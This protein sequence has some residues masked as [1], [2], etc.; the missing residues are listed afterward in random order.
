MRFHHMVE[1]YTLGRIN[2]DML[3]KHIKQY[4]SELFDEFKF[5]ELEYLKIYPFLSEFQDEELYRE[6]ILKDK[7]EEINNILNGKKS[8]SYD[9]WMN[10]KKCELN[11]F[12]EI[13]AQYKEIGKI[14]FED[15][16]LLQTKLSN[17][18]LNK[19]TVEDICW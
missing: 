1:E 12:Y 7:I 4:F 2:A 10:L 17:I 14:S 8:F 6:D 15:S 5:R 11:Y 18:T 9:L 3:Y 13:L 16:E 19:K